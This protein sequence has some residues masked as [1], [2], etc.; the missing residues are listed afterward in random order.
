MVFLYRRRQAINELVSS[1]LATR[2]PGPQ[3]VSAKICVHR[4][5]Q[6]VLVRSFKEA[7]AVASGTGRLAFQNAVGFVRVSLPSTVAIGASTKEDLLLVKETLAHAIAL[8]MKY[9]E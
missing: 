3:G 7:T 5:V 8:A 6:A 9:A 2:R 1:S 4:V